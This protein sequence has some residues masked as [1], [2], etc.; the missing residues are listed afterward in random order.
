MTK[1]QEIARNMKILKISRKEA[2]EMY[3]SDHF[4][5]LTPEMEEMEKK[6]KKIKRYEKSDK[7]RKQSE[8]IRKIDADKVELFE[9]LLKAIKN[10]NIEIKS[11]KNEAEFSFCFH[12]S[13]Y[14]IK[15]IK[16]RP[17]KK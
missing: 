17:T 3:M 7:P 1:E 5:I 16:H 2:E 15:L 12:D 4:D 8:R 11:Q 13:E 6:A 9:I 14:S 10:S